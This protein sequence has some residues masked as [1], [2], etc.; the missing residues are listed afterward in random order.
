[1]K[2]PGNE[3]V[4]PWVLLEVNSA[5]LGHAD[6]R[7]KKPLQGDAVR[8]DF[9]SA[10]ADYLDLDCSVGTEATGAHLFLPAALLLPGATSYYR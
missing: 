6:I 4:V 2:S 1:M 9:R 10:G 5:S 8:E 7:N 3:N